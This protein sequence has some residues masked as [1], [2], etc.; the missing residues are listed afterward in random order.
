LLFFIH[1]HTH[2]P[3]TTLY[4]RYSICLRGRESSRG[5]RVRAAHAA[6]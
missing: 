3:T 2:T 1:T 5:E 6:V 4:Y